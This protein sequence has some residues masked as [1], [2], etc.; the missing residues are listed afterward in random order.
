MHSESL[1]AVTDMLRGRQWVRDAHFDRVYPQNVQDVSAHFWTPVSIALTGAEWLREA[2][3]HSLLDVGAGAG[4][5][6]I[7]TRLAADCVTEGIEQRS[8]LVQ[9]ARDAALGYGADVRFEHGTIEQVDP[10]RFDAFYF[11]NPFG[12]NHYNRTD[13]FDQTVE[14]SNQRCMR[15]L[16]VVERWLDRAE[17][18]TKVL[19]Y[20]GFGGRMPDTYLLAHSKTSRGGALRLWVKRRSGRTR[21]FSLELDDSII[22]SSQLEEL[23][24]RLDLSCGERVRELLDRPFE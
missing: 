17:V 23:A 22:V 9:T 12:E 19:T 16:A 10:S 11:Y 13:C 7:V 3:C 1:H 2:G 4:K 18:G 14:L 8:T 5:F 15:D 20:H 21:G 24:H 6:C